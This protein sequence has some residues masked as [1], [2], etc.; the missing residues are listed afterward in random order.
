MIQQLF[1]R[2]QGGSFSYVSRQPYIPIKIAITVSIATVE[3]PSQSFLGAGAGAAGIAG[4][5]IVAA[6]AAA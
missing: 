3:K 2:K 4:V 6:A 1:T 5:S